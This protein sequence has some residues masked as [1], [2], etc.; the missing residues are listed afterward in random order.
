MCGPGVD[1]LD[2]GSTHR[3]RGC[4]LVLSSVRTHM[5]VYNT[6][7]TQRYNNTHTPTLTH[8]ER[9]FTHN[10][11]TDTTHT[12]TET[13][14]QTTSHISTLNGMIHTHI[15]HICT[16]GSPSVVVVVVVVEAKDASFLL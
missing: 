16:H 10:T 11:H 7:Y 1:L 2:S 4:T 15:L 3:E 8:S 5:Y 6:S 14:I 13:H 12:Y 9:Y